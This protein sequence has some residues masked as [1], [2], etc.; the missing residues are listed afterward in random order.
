KS[1]IKITMYDPTPTKSDAMAAGRV[2][3]LGRKIVASNGPIVP[4]ATPEIPNQ[5]SIPKD[6]GGLSTITYAII[7]TTTTLSL[8]SR[9][10]YFSVFSGESFIIFLLTRNFLKISFAII[11]DI[12]TNK[13]SV[14]EIAAAITV[15]PRKAATT[16]GKKS[17]TYW[18]KAW[19][20]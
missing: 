11:V 10:E 7:P 14:V 13:P 1:S 4:E 8:L 16:G 20:G 15:I 17:S 9:S 18:S 19:S 2:A 6:S 5:R 12:T 3:R